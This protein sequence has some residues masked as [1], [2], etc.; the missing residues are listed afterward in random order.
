MESLKLGGLF[1]KQVSSGFVHSLCPMYMLS[2]CM[3]DIEM[4]V[5]SGGY[6]AYCNLTLLP[7]VSP[8]SYVKMIPL[9]N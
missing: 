4:W 7:W 8:E 5:F 3:L 9:L 1:V 6:S 2:A